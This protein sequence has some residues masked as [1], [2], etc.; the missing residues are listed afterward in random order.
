MSFSNL[1]QSLPP[2]TFIDRASYS[3]WRHQMETF[4]RYW[5]FVRGIHRWPVNTPH[6][7]QWRG[8]LIFCLMSAWINSQVN[9]REAGDLRRYRA[10]YDVIV[11]NFH[12][13]ILIKYFW[14]FSNETHNVFKGYCHI[15]QY[16]ILFRVYKCMISLSNCICGHFVSLFFENTKTF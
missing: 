14:T 10:H 15:P 12:L 11:M 9:N 16:H 2:T 5:P 4:P 6:K 7:G 1:F 13:V 8:A 3:W